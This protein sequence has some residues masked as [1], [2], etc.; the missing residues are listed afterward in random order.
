VRIALK[1]FFV[2]LAMWF[3]AVPAAFAQVVPGDCEEGTLST[4]ARWKICVPSPWNR[5]L[6]VFAHGYIPDVPGVGLG[7]FDTLPDGTAISDVVQGLGF[8]YATTSYST[9]GLAILEGIDDVRELVAL[10]KSTE[11]EPART[12]MTGVSEGGLVAALLAERSPELFTGAYSLCGPIGNFQT[13]L[14]YVGDFRV[15]FDYFFPGVFVG[16]AVQI[17]PIDVALWLQDI[18]PKVIAD[19]LRAEPGKAI[20]LMRTAKAS[21][22]PANFDTVVQTV[23]SVL[24]Y[25]ILG[26]SNA[27]FKLGGQPFDNRFRLYFGSKNDLHLNLKVRRFTADLRATL[28]VQNYNASGVLPIPLVTLH[29]SDDEAVPFGHELLYLA[30]ARPTGRGRFLPLPVVRYGHCNLTTQEI[31]F[32]FA[33]LLAQP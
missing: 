13:Q 8:A 20:E 29:T 19:R 7:F 4:G 5:Q 26:A 15:L 21:Y 10:F 16:S 14:N 33:V 1:T 32:G 11:G 30:K 3:V 9:N 25:N 24:R 12:F 17:A 31:L 27:I 6:V 2:A 28:A 18:T 22:D 23:K